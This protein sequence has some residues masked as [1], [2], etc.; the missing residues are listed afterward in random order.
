MITDALEEIRKMEYEVELEKN[1]GK[2]KGMQEEI[3]RKIGEIYKRVEKELDQL[4]PRIFEGEESRELVEIAEALG[5][6]LAKNKL[7]TSQIRNVYARVKEGLGREEI[8]MLRPLLAYA[9][10]RHSSVKP[11]QRVL[12]KA[13][14][15]IPR[16]EEN[17]KKYYKKFRDFFQAILA[18]HRYYG[19][20]E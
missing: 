8:D 9:A 2:R 4:F 1:P 13:L 7:T 12:D 20:K 11:L 3:R 17:Y 6:Y 5:C 18:Y 15:K 16:E 10:A 14:Q 19:G